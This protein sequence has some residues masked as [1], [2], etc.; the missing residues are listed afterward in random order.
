MLSITLIGIAILGIIILILLWKFNDKMREIV[1]KIFQKKY[2]SDESWNRLNRFLMIVGLI[3]FIFGAGI[4]IYRQVVYMSGGDPTLKDSP[5]KEDLINMEERLDKRIMELARLLTPTS[6]DAQAFPDSLPKPP[7]EAQEMAQSLLDLLEQ[8]KR[9]GAEIPLSYLLGEGMADIATG[10]SEEG[11]AKILEYISKI[12]AAWDQTQDLLNQRLFRSYKSLGDAEYYSHNYNDALNWY[13]KA[14]EISRND[15]HALNG[16]GLCGLYLAEYDAAKEYFKGALEAEALSG[17]D[18]SADYAMYLNNLGGVLQ[19]QADYD[20][21][22]ENCRKALDIDMKLFGENHR[23]VARDVSNIG[24][25]LREQGDYVGALENYYRALNIIKNIHG[26]IH[27]YVAASYNNIGLARQAQGDYAGAL[28]N[29]RKALDIDMKIF[30][31][32]HPKVA[33]RY[34]NIAHLYNAMD[35]PEEGLPYIIEAYK[36]QLRFLGSD[37]PNTKNTRLGVQILGGD[38]E[39]VEREVREEGSP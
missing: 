39:A 6:I 17:G 25:A 22:L 37:H 10:D 34:H 33:I 3:S 9:S 19:A 31:E 38:P 26:E 13:D 32:N 36:I 14:L 23:N 27:P 2:I 7:P 21:A 8:F 5:S 12:E 24:S 30:G 1:N 28:D 16:A 20:G 29:F 11:K 4:F 35:K 15:A 18:K